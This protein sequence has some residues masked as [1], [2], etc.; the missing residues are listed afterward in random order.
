MAAPNTRSHRT[1]VTASQIPA[2]TADQRQQHA[3]GHELAHHPAAIGTERHSNPDLALTPD[4][5]RE[6]QPTDV[7]AGD[8]QYEADRG[9]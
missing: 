3:L 8:E 4:A 6:Q 9:G 1:P 5:S 7:D 2:T